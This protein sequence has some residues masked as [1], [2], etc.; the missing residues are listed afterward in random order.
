[1]PLGFLVGDTSNGIGICTSVR[2][3]GHE[4][5]SFVGVAHVFD[6]SLLEVSSDLVEKRK[7]I[8]YVGRK[9]EIEYKGV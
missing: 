2:W 5:T 8:S 4:L 1:M 7:V 6:D 9:S 3:D